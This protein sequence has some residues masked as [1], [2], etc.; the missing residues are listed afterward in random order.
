MAVLLLPSEGFRR[1]LY[2]GTRGKSHGTPQWHCGGDL[3]CLWIQKEE[4]EMNEPVLRTNPVDAQ[5]VVLPNDD[6][7][8]AR[9]NGLFGK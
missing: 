6:K 7:T 4:E 8:L 2:L 9:R 1:A 5:L 3:L